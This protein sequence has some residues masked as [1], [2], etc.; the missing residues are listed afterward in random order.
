M[1]FKKI[2]TAAVMATA[3]ATVVTSP[4]SAMNPVNCGDRT[5]FLRVTENFSADH[6]YANAGSVSYGNGIWVS[7]ISSGNNDILWM[8]D[9]SYH[10][11]ARWNVIT[12][13][14]AGTVKLQLVAIKTV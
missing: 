7:K 14:S 4:A 8:A 10:D 2:A 11:L 5:D 1:S 13:P 6:C 12:W 3:L 9:G